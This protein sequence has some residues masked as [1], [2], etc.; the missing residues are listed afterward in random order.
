MR[1]TFALAACCVG[2]AGPAAAQPAL[3]AGAG[4]AYAAPGGAPP[5]FVFLG[6]E[7][8]FELKTVKG[9]PYS[10]ATETEI[11]QP[12]ADGNRISSR[13]TGFVA[14]DSEGRTRREQAMKPDSRPDASN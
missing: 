12:L 7:G 11:S 6:A 1:R 5:P 10:A 4:V 9:A 3:G 13:S 14:R 8:A 2:M